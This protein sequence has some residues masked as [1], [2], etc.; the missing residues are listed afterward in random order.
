MLKRLEL[1]GFKSFAKLTK[2]EFPAAVSA[3]VGPN[4]S[5]KSNI[6]EAMR[7]VLGEQSMKSLR[8]KKGEDLIF[9]GSQMAPKLG[10]A[11]VSL[12]LDNRKKIIPIDY[13]E[14]KITRKVFRDGINDYLINDSIV[15]H[16]DVVELLSKIGLG[17]SSHY[18]ISQGEADRIL[19][20]SLRERRQ[21]IED[22]LGLKIY[23]LKKTEAERKL[24][25]TEDNMN[26]VETLKREI[27]PHLKFLKKQ[28]EKAEEVFSLRD[29]LKKIYAVYFLNENNY[30]KTNEKKIID[31]KSAVEKEFHEI[32]KELHGA[33]E[34][35]QTRSVKLKN[36]IQELRNGA[37][38][39]E[40]EAGELR[41]KRNS[42][43]RE[44]GRIEGILEAV[45]AEKKQDDNISVPLKEVKN[46]A[47]EIEAGIDKGLAFE[48]I[49]KMIRDFLSR[50]GSK[51]FTSSP[52]LGDLK[53]KQEETRKLLDKISE[54]E[55]ELTEK[56]SVLKSEITEKENQLHSLEKE[57]Y[58]MEARFKE[59]E[60]ILRNLNAR[61]ENFDMQKNELEMETREARALLGE[62]EGKPSFLE[63][64]RFPLDWE[65]ERA[66]I[67]RDVERMKIRVEDSGAID[68]EVLK[69]FEEVRKRDEFFEKEL[70]DLKQAVGS[71]KNLLL[72]LEEKIDRDFKVGIEKINKEFQKFF[73][74]M[75]GGGKA[76][77]RR[78]APVK[79]VKKEDPE[80]PTSDVGE[81]EN[82]EKEEG[83]EVYVNLPKKRIHSLDALSGGE[84]ALTSIAL[85]F[86]M[87]QVNP[88]PF[89]VLDETDAALDEA[90]S[91]KYGKMLNNLSK[92]TQLIVITHNRETMK[93]AGILYGVTMGSDSVSKI[94][95]IKFTEA[96]K[97][98]N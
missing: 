81:V 92:Q 9:N 67:R 70:A 24:E 47:E 4:G 5:G 34:G 53:N 44:L 19:N 75:F 82:E 84:R 21:M 50:I 14:V 69:E 94:L 42:T 22:A 86:A 90:N 77:L 64:T 35:S 31:E 17:T 95:S 51:I 26:Q 79:R 46:F 43:E 25:K 20:T 72:E 93:Q 18:I 12:I 61:K 98:V 10:K 3:V 28:V 32:K 62:M 39:K 76:E 33:P 16:K 6:A 68:N 55:K 83:I 89:L 49:K 8:G 63:E 48:Q 29:K 40:A 54:T 13:D 73:D 57:R 15:R 80:D 87:S 65:N 91:Q 97:I 78:V 59:L 71:L 1:S 11:S 2:L 52:N 56:I 7:W 38:N 60:G 37:G 36:E 58:S 88:P 85:L 30:L 66:K 41:L 45:E 27:Q 96:E 74:E 23:Q